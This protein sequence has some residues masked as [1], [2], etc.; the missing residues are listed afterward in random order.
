MYARAD[1]SLTLPGQ[2]LQSGALSFSDILHDIGGV[3]G[4]KREDIEAIVA[5]DAK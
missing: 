1:Q 4:L 5:R 2:P 3:L